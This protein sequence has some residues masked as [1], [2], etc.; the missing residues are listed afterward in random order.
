MDSRSTDTEGAAEV[1]FATVCDKRIEYTWI[2]S[3][4]D[5][6]PVLVF[7]HEGLGCVAA[8]KDFPAQL[9]KATGLACLTYSRAG[10]GGSDPMPP[11]S[12][13]GYLP[14]Q[15]AGLHSVLN[16]FRIRR[17]LFVGHSDGATIALMYAGES[18]VPRAAGI[19]LEAPHVFIESIT[20]EG[21]TAATRLYKTTDFR[22]KLRRYHGNKTDDTFE[23]WTTA[24]Q[25]PDA[26]DW[27][28]E[29]LL[30]PIRAPTLVI[31]GRD[32]EY[33]TLAQVEAITD[34]CSGPVETEI[35][36]A[37]GHIPHKQRK[38]H[39]LAVMADFIERRVVVN[40]SRS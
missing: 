5:S 7:L 19:I 34:G 2:G 31:Q 23:A 21:I 24:W 37:C 14:S 29:A 32:D 15:I 36:D 3:Q 10:Y 6:E 33:G 28:I 25:D 9:A 12:A 1:S 38:E 20:L 26:R 27:N 16:H 30:S 40:W 22:T 8:W 35:L 11:P 39:T 4:T 17:P 13:A 18:R